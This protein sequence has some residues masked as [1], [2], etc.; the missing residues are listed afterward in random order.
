MDIAADLRPCLESETRVPPPAQDRWRL[1]WEEALVELAPLVRALGI[2]ADRRDDVLHDVY[3]VVRQKAPPE[4]DAD[5]SRRWLLR[6]TANRCRLEH[7]RRSRWTRLFDKR[8]QGGQPSAAKAGTAVEQDE[9]SAEV[10]AAL[11]RLAAI[12]R[13]IV[14]LR[15]FCEL[16]SREIGEVLA[17]PEATVRSR[18]AKARRQLARDLAAFDDE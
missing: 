1:A 7:R 15:Y 8:V 16:N 12:E 9:L 5:A 13:E 14:V 2:P 18:L 4:M 17:M 11:D 10:D 3:F 6:V